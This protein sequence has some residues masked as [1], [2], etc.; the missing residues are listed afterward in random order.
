MNGAISFAPLVPWPY[1]AAICA[2]I[3]VLL[4]IGAWRR[5][6]GLILRLLA[7]TI[8]AAA[9]FNPRIVQERRE[10]QPDVAVVV[11][12]E[13]A[14]QS[15]GER[16]AQTAK[17]L[18]SLRKNLSRFK[19]LEVRV[20][21]TG[22]AGT[23]LADEGTQ[24]FTTLNKALGE[25]ATQR[26]AGAVVITD[27]QIH[28]VPEPGKGEGKIE[29]LAGP[30]HFLLT[31]SQNERDR[32]LVV[33][34]APSYGIVGSDITISYK[35]ED[36][37]GSDGKP[38]RLTVRRDGGTPE[39]IAA[40]VGRSST[41]KF[42]LDHAGPTVIELE[43]SPMPGE[44]SPINNRAVV[45]VNGV[46]D[47]LRVLLVSGKPHAGERVWRS[48]LKSD[49]SVDLVHFTILRPPDKEDMTPNRELALIVFP[50]RQLFEVKLNEFNL[51]IFDRYSVIDVLPR[52]YL[53]NITEY[54]RK[55]GALM[56]ATGPEFA[57][58]RSLYQTPLGAVMPG[59]PTGE[60]IEQAFRASYT[61]IGRRHPVTDPLLT[62]AKGGPSWGRWFR[63]IAVTARSGKTLL[64]GVNNAPLLILDRV[65]KG[66]VAEL[67]SDHLW[68]WARGYDGG[69]P[70]G[71]LLRRLAHWLMKEPELEEES[72]RA[73][74]E[75]GKLVIRRR[76]LEPKLPPVT[77]TTPTGATKTV[78]LR[79]GQGG[80]ASASIAAD[81]PGLYRI[82]D[83]T[84]TALAAAG[85]L[86]PVEMSDLRATGE[87]LEKVVA[88]TNGSIHWISELAGGGGVPEL[89][90]TRPGRDSAGRSWIGLRQ[91]DSYIVTG[92]QQLPLLPGLL[93]LLLG[94]AGLM[95][96]WFR[97]GKG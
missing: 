9:L 38:A 28:D 29:N 60:V 4:C 11:V 1:I 31:G 16:K 94:I 2:V 8:L 6:K 70:Q 40:P 66:R 83:G 69:G 3:A 25:I 26:F 77:V 86:N 46:H 23:A 90:R 49:P 5:G 85:A 50:A 57:G 64:S 76:S 59:A 43:A 27:G 71:E 93:I 42:T 14:S 33:E 41:Y 24:L 54:V 47:R 32:R 82:E 22:E 67:A 81:E 34:K 89:R 97:E 13:S 65:G 37:P 44:L 62:D 21:R 15:I 36:R 91:N 63:Q 88:M 95:A 53:E 51:V 52:S 12:D 92:I 75:T 17:A 56:I 87:H 45:S 48:L 73:S 35:I 20:V 74:V 96:A 72:L 30:L 84:R 79:S 68:L 10:G 18:D 39:T 55:G 61:D 78:T 7:V 80:E 58:D 19:N